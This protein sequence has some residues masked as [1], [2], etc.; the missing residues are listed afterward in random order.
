MDSIQESPSEETKLEIIRKHL[1]AL[2]VLVVA[3]IIGCVFFYN[4][5]RIVSEQTAIETSNEPLMTKTIESDPAIVDS[6]KLIYRDDSLGF[7][8][9]LPK[10]WSEIGYIITD[11]TDLRIDNFTDIFDIRFDV[12][13]K[14]NKLI[15]EGDEVYTTVSRMRV[16]PVDEYTKYSCFVE[17]DEYGECVDV[18]T[19]I[20]R[21]DKYVFESYRQCMEKD[22]CYNLAVPGKNLLETNALSIYP[23]QGRDLKLHSINFS[24]TEQFVF[25]S[26]EQLI[27]QKGFPNMDDSSDTILATFSDRNAVPQFSIARYDIV[28]G[29]ECGPFFCIDDSNPQSKDGMGTLEDGKYMLSSNWSMLHINLEANSCVSEFGEC[30]NVSSAYIYIGAYGKRYYVLFWK[31]NTTERIVVDTIVQKP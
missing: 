27:V 22:Q 21:N 26:P 16:Y 25:K 14:T 18:V 28:D 2:L 20:G 9:E 8:V 19:E 15:H 5:T 11:E 24:D 17:P 30:E 1:P 23:A 10:E 3:I 7:S 6:G 4:Y 31:G 13:D 12:R 29:R